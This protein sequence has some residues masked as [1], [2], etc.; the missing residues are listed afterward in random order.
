MYAIFLLLMGQHLLSGAVH[1]WLGISLFVLFITHNVLNYRFYT[2]L[3]KGKYSVIRI[4]QTIIN[5]LL[6]TAMLLC[7]ASSMMIS[8]TVFKWM[9]LSGGRRRTGDPSYLHRMD[10]YPDE[11]AFGLALVLFRCHQQTDKNQSNGENRSCL[12]TSCG[13]PCACC[14]RNIRFHNKAIL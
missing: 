1:E 8:G 14:V 3:F 5:L 10:V 7:I 11:S 4:V 2:T 6:L 9:N 12:A 13:H